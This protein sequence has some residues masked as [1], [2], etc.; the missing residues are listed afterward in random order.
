MGDVAATK[1][2]R[3]KAEDLIRRLLDLVDD[4]YLAADRSAATALARRLEGALLALRAMD[5]PTV[6]QRSR[7]GTSGPAPRNPWDS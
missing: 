1:M 7:P 3:R 2:K 6:P 4:G 5:G